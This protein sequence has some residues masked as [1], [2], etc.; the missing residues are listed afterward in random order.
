MQYMQ[1]TASIFFNILLDTRKNPLNPGDNYNN[2]GKM[3]QAH[4]FYDLN[5]LTNHLNNTLGNFE[6]LMDN[7]T[8]RILGSIKNASGDFRLGKFYKKTVLYFFSMT[9]KL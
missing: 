6:R 4:M 2:I 5:Q 3:S 1:F 7:N 9:A 8:N